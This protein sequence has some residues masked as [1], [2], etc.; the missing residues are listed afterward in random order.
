MPRH[1]RRSVPDGPAFQKGFQASFKL[2]T[3]QV[4]NTRNLKGFVTSL[5]HFQIWFLELGLE[6]VIG[7]YLNLRHHDPRFRVVDAQAF[8]DS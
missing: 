8:L 6:L 3:V 5:N 2:V 4:T 7:V 1:S